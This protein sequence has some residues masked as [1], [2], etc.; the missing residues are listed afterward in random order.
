MNSNPQTKMFFHRKKIHESAR[1][2]KV[3]C[4]FCMG[5]DFLH[6]FLFSLVLSLL[7]EVGRSSTPRNTLLTRVAS[8]YILFLGEIFLVRNEEKTFIDFHFC[9]AYLEF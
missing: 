6:R 4:V 3:M 7:R 9:F 8:I 1:H 5:H 2:P